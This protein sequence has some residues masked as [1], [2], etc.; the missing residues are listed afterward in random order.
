MNI[1]AFWVNEHGEK[2]LI[3]PPL[4]GTILPGVTRDS[5]L[6]LCRNLGEFKVTV[7]P[8]KIQELMKASKEKRLIEVF[9]AGTAVVVSPV[10]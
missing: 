5:I 6:T 9:C 1:F 3:T 8:F 7:R 2:E 4:D 10:C